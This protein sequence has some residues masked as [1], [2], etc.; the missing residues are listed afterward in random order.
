MS[1]CI[2]NCTIDSKEKAIEIAKKLV[3][4]K[5]IACCNIIPSITSVYKWKGK[6]NEDNEVLMIMK[7]ET[8][9]FVQIEEEI[10]KLHPYDI[11]EIICTP[12][13]NGNEDYLKWLD[14]QTLN[15]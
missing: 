8:A 1:Y 4:E 12:I 11:P 3:E 10:T 7:T 9:L 13:I 15:S 6:L 5:L 14:E 2:V